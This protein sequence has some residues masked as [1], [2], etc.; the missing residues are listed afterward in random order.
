MTRN[1]KKVC[2]LIQARMRSSRLPGKVLEELSDGKTLLDLQFERLSFSKTLSMAGIVTTG[3]PQDDVIAQW[4]RDQKVYCYRGSE[5]DVLDRYYRAAIE[6]KADIVVRLT[7][8]CPMI[9]PSI[10]DEAVNTILD[11]S[12]KLDYVGNNEPIPGTYPDG[13]DVWVFTMNALERSWHDAIKPSE[14]EHVS[15]YVCNHPD[16][17]NLKRIEAPRDLSSY[18]FTIDYPDDLLAIRAVHQELKKRGEF[19]SYE[20][21]VNIMDD[22]PEIRDI[23][24]AYSFGEGWEPSFEA[25]TS[26]NN[27]KPDNAPP[28]STASGE[29]H[30]KRA[31]ECVA[32]GGQTF[33]K[34][35]GQYVDGVAPKIL[36]RGRGCRV[37]DLDG[38]EFVDCVLG[39]GPVILGHCYPEVDGYVQD[40]V[41]DCF[42]APSLPHPLELKVAEQLS[43]HIP[44]A[45]MVRFGKNG[46]DVTSS[47][48]RLARYYTG[49]DEV[50]CCGY[51]GWQDWYIGG[52]SRN[53]GVPS[54]VQK[55]VYHWGY[56]NIESLDQIFRD[57]P[58]RIAAV[59]MEPV[60]FAAP[61]PGFLNEVQDLCRKHGALLIF[62]EIIT[63]FRMNIGGAQ[64]EFDITPDI[65]CFGKAMGNGYAVSAICGR[66]ELMR[67][68]DEVFFSSTFGGELSGLAAAQKTMEIIDREDICS[69]IESV[70]VFFKAKLTKIVE[71]LNMPYV[72]FQG[73]GWMPLCKITGT[74]Q[75][76]VYE[77]LT[78][79]QQ[80]LVKRG[81]LTRSAL[82]LSF[83]H[84]IPDIR[85][86][87]H[88]YRGALLVLKEAVEGK[89]VL[90]RTEGRQIE[91]VIRGAT[92]YG[93]PANSEE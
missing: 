90:E 78:L 36:A 42:A 18:R 13:M 51:H 60:S 58:D 57:Q 22:R 6:L 44:C 62:D 65:G 31:I 71:E 80:E 15:F 8:D 38:N 4:C 43:S 23:N 59:I 70:G 9:D 3:S 26:I 11:D 30:W 16:I 12:N 21:L 89:Q 10:I 61:K 17:F 54:Y 1:D 63:G 49:R 34:L 79:F 53:K 45:E 52:T 19:G 20:E 28:L 35:P 81:V 82:F 47:A 41:S 84:R 83:S 85:T 37:W 48:I 50:A 66:G 29:E 93:T 33:S 24:N 87:I 39:L 69:Q 91:P 88:A 75:Y 86:M 68:F 2:A 14:R 74:E 77:L 25:D 55:L 32:T 64:K 40:V 67:L 76:G 72:E 5:K 7:S 92:L 56:N 46:S 73:Y 27:L